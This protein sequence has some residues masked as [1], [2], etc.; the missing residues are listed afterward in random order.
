VHDAAGTVV[1]VHHRLRDGSRRYYPP[2]AKARPFLIG[3]IVA[4]DSVHCFESQWDAFAFMDVSG[5]R[6]AIVIS[7][8]AANGALLA[9]QLTETSTLYLWTQ[10][11]RA[12]EKWQRDILAN[13]QAEVKR[14]EIPTPHKDL[15]DWTRAG[16]TV[17]GLLDAM[18][19]AH[20]ECD[21]CKAYPSIR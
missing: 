8:G 11:D 7:R 19:S 18:V 1:A 3:E 13:T 15:N 16:V 21:I 10:N 14:A 20:L 5:E 17:E 2:G 12:G 4:G 6:S 9:A